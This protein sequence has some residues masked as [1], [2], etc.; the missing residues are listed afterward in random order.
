MSPMFKH[1]MAAA[2]AACGMCLLPAAHAEKKLTSV[3]VTVGV[4]GLVL[5]HIVL[6]SIVN[7]RFFSAPIAIG[8]PSARVH[9]IEGPMSG[10]KR[11][12]FL[13]FSL[14]AFRP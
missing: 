8:P 12:T 13:R 5:S 1:W 14:A 2:I 11:R 7:V 10:P 6:F 3:G 9:E 4:L